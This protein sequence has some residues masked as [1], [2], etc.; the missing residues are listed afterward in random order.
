MPN[1]LPISRLVNVAITLTQ[2]AAQAQNT[3]TLLILGTS[4]VIDLNSR[5]RSY[6][7][8]GDLAA[9]FGTN[10]EEYKAAV[11]WFEQSP[12]PTSV[13]VG[14]WAKTAAS[15][16]L[17]GATLSAAHAALTNFTAVTAG[18]MSV[19]IDG[20]QKTLSAINLSAVTN[21]N[22]VASAVTTALAGAATCV[23]DASFGRFELSSA[24]TGATSSVGFASAPGTGTDISALLGLTST[25][26]GAYVA[27]GVAAETAVSAVTLFDQNFGQQWYALQIPSAV[28]ADHLS[29]ATYIEA[30]STRH[31]YGVTTQEPAVLVAGDTSNIAYQLKGLG[32][33]KTAVQYSSSNA[34]AVASLLSRIMTTDYTANN[35]VITL[36]FKQEPGITAENLNTTQANAL[37]A[38]NCNVFVAYENDTAIIEQGVCC[39]GDFID[40]IIGADNF[41][42]D[43]QNSVFNLL[44]TS[45]TKIP[46][47]DAGNHMIATR[48][49]KICSQYVANGFLAPGTWESGGFGTLSEGDYLPKGFYVYAPSIA[50]QS[51][52]DRAAR[53]S[54]SFQVAAKMAGAIHSVDIAVTVNQ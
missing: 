34:Y 1:L 11:L 21:L 23:W 36:K 39:S 37:E 51:P 33:K 29:V 49:E 41:A 46:Q 2:K 8:I 27:A 20:T 25:S 44:Y 6:A 35:T 52:A 47:T 10:S 31:F 42:I 53:K 3:S 16:Q 30:A 13:M 45:T 22:G 26:S 7:D 28:D 54:V 32:Y 18:G 48:I 15:G 40:S 24:T 38:F 50:N 4:A 9:D 17:I 43:V 14:R 12:Q 19:T 5:L